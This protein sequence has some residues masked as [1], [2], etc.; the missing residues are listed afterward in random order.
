[1][2]VEWLVVFSHAIPSQYHLLQASDWLGNLGFEMRGVGHIDS[3]CVNLTVITCDSSTFN[4][5]PTKFLRTKPG[6]KNTS[7]DL[8]KIPISFLLVGLGN[9]PIKR[10]YSGSSFWILL[11]TCKRKSSHR[12]L[13]ASFN[14]R[15]SISRYNKGH[16]F[17]VPQYWHSET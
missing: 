9:I 4:S 7:L 8:A 14:G 10:S 2:L 17:G 13:L 1:M 6:P 3:S 11:G 15:G 12:L 16:Y 5:L